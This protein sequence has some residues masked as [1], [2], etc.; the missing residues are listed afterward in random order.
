MLHLLL[1]HDDDAAPR[2]FRRAS[3]DRRFAKGGSSSQSTSATTNNTDNST[4]QIDNKIATSGTSVVAGAGA[5]IGDI[6]WESQDAATTKA[7][8]DSAG[9]TAGKAIDGNAAVA[10]AALG[11]AAALGETATRAAVDTNAATLAFTDK[12][13]ARTADAFATAKSGDAGQLQTTLKQ[14]A[15]VALVGGTVIG[16]LFLLRK[17]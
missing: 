7:A 10:A 15:L 9:M 17:K 16:G 6:N 12:A 8:I 1:L 2:R 4:H 11:T 14:I 5:S 3:F 13:I